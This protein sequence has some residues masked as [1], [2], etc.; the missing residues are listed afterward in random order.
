GVQTA[1]RQDT[2]TESDGPAISSSLRKSS[3]SGSDLIASSS[4]MTLEQYDELY[5]K[6]I[7]IEPPG[8]SPSPNNIVGSLCSLTLEVQS[9]DEI[10]LEDPPNNTENHNPA[11]N[12]NFQSL[13]EPKEDKALDLPP[14]TTAKDP[15]DDKDIAEESKT[16]SC[17]LS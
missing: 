2:A 10:V 7:Q 5:H 9:E 11:D 17:K 4:A 13:A 12:W 14:P 16:L 3:S 6:Y 15:N 8:V 1:Q